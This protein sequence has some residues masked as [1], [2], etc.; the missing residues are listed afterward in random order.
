MSINVRV[1]S[2]Q[3]ALAK[4]SYTVWPWYRLIEDDEKII[5]RINEIKH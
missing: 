2:E 1:S 4:T 3:N 5:N